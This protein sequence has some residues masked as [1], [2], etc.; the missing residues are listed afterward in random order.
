LITPN[1]FRELLKRNVLKIEK[2]IGKGITMPLRIPSKTYSKKK[3]SQEQLDKILQIE[4]ALCEKTDAL[5]LAGHLQAIA[6]KM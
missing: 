4:F 6:Y 3:Y 1:E 2:I 5:G